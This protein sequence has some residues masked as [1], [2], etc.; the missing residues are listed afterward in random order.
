MEYKDYPKLKYANNPHENP[1]HCELDRIINKDNFF[2]VCNSVHHRTIQINHQT[3]VT[4][5]QFIILTFIYSSTCFG[6]FPAHYQELNDCSG[7]LWFYIR[8][9]VEPACR[10][11]HEYSTTVTTIQR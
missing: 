7:S 1:R 11:D 5:F 6:P 3:D 9:V 10:P 4:I 8:I 2:K